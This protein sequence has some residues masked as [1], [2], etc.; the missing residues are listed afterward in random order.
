MQLPIQKYLK[1][2]VPQGSVLGPLLFLVY[3][4]DIVEDMESI[5]RL[6]A[7]DTSMSLAMENQFLRAQILNRDLGR[8]LVWADKWKVVFNE[9]KTEMLYFSKRPDQYLPLTFGNTRLEKI[10]EHKH[11]GVTLQENCKWDGHIRSVVSKVSMLISCLKSFKYRLCRRTLETMYRSFVLPH[12]DY[13][14][15]LWD[16]CTEFLAT[17]LEDLHLEALRTITG[18]VR[19]TSH[20][21]LYQESGFCSLK[22]RRRRHKLLV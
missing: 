13:A 19:G 6:F 15:I 22:E 10:D 14:D 8:I 20:Q 2:G 4:N 7:D 3:I 9:G 17:T 18:S 1:A 11:L 16:N 21:K 12:F 5:A